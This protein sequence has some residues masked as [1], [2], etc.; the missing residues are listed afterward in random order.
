M[1][2]SEQ[3]EFIFSPEYAFGSKGCPPR[4]PADA[5]VYFRIELINWIDS[6]DAEAYGKL[7]RTKQKEASF[8]HMLAAAQ[9]QKR[10]ATSFVEKQSFMQVIRFFSAHFCLCNYLQCSFEA[11]KAYKQALNWIEEHGYAD[12]QEEKQGLKICLA[13]NLDL[14]LVYLKLNRPKKTCIYCREALN[15]DPNNP[16]AHYRRGLAQEKLGNNMEARRCLLDAK[17]ILPNDRSINKALI[18]VNFSIFFLRWQLS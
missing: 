3:S 10:L 9:S 18:E 8:Q 7:P 6:S 15:I 2:K 13:L 5:Y 16:K 4:I 1:K 14:A 17:R 12:E 11:A